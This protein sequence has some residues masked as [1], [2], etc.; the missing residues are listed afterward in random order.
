MEAP[1]QIQCHVLPAVPTAYG[2]PL[3]SQNCQGSPRM[4]E[5][6]TSPSNTHTHTRVRARTCV[7]RLVFQP[8][9][10]R[11]GFL[12]AYHPCLISTDFNK[13]PCLISSCILSNLAL[14]LCNQGPQRPQARPLRTR[15]LKEGLRTGEGCE[16]T[17]RGRTEH[18][19]RED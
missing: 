16:T 19:D 14:P 13:H 1:L 15:R 3:V 7:C 10:S 11:V 4:V 6:E 18:R 17:R 9:C 8:Q 2:E 12:P 5:G